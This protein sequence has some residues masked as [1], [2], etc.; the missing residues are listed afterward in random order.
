MGSVA[1][2]SEF[3]SNVYAGE[4]L[5]THQGSL[6][7]AGIS[8]KEEYRD[9]KEYRQQVFPIAWDREVLDDHDHVGH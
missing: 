9:T 5:Y 6:F 1:R 2:A 7:P 8:V 4:F 3:I